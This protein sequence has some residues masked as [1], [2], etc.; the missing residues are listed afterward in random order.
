MNKK[1]KTDKSR[2]I[3]QKKRHSRNLVWKKYLYY[4]FVSSQ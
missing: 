1:S 3:K 4:Y 2:N